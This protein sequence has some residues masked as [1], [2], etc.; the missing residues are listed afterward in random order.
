M[1]SL[2]KLLILILFSLWSTATA[3]AI[4]LD[5]LFVQSVGGPVAV[6]NLRRMISYQAEGSVVLNGMPGRFVEYFVP[7]DRFYSELEFG[8]VTIVQAYDGRIAWQKDMN[9]QVSRLEGF[10]RDEILKGLYFN[11]F[12]YLFPDRFEG[13]F[14]YQGELTKDGQRYHAVAFVPLQMDT[15]LGY[16][17]VESGRLALSTSFADELPIYTYR[18]K[19][20]EVGGIRWPILLEVVAEG[21]PASMQIEY[22]TITLNEAIEHSIFTLPTSSSTDFGFP[23]GIDS[24]VVQFV[25][26]AGHI[27]LPVVVNGT[28]KV[29]MI[30]DDSG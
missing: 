11:S 9:G 4:D 13:S 6:D 25:Y 26:Q 23:E 27:R 22:E 3:G 28:V 15:V 2:K 24:V 12:S 7:P 17:D 20:E 29:W 19:F 30:L 8:P 14:S 5:S 18:R 21:A 1:R 10:E 16:F